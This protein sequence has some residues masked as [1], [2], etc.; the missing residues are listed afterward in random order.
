MSALVNV[1]EGCAAHA[2]EEN[3]YEAAAA[4]ASM[5]RVPLLDC[6]DSAAVA[7]TM[8]MLRMRE[9][10]KAGNSDVINLVDWGFSRKFER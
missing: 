5:L 9:E 8:A 10:Q 2:A 6:A 1:R 3:P 7:A 4:A